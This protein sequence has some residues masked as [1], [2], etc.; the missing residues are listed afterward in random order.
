MQ[1]A[2]SEAETRF[3]LA[4]AGASAGLVQGV[5]G[6]VDMAAP[7]APARIAALA[8]DPLLKSLRPMLQDIT[9]DAWM[10]DPRLD[11]AFR[12][13]IELGLCFDALVQPRHLP[14]LLRLIERYPELPVVIDHGAKPRIAERLIEPWAADIGAIARHTRAWC[15]LSGLVT[16]ARPD[17]RAEDVRPYVARLLEEF[18]PERLMWGSDWPVVNLAGGYKRWRGATLEL[19]RELQD[20]ERRAILGANA[21]AFYGLGYAG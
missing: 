18:G 16:E 12:A 5:V 15:K 11:P 21:V 19:L 9:D 14:F 7:D 4:A 13:L 17:W 8:R 10:L 6:W 1:A 2:P 3:L 20:G